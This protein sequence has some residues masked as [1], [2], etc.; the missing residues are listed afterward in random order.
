MVRWWVLVHY[1]LSIELCSAW[2]TN[3][4][5]VPT[6]NHYFYHFMVFSVPSSLVLLLN[7]EPN[8]GHKSYSVYF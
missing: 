5:E 3:C 4:L 7:V 8:F 2:V 6:L 1:G